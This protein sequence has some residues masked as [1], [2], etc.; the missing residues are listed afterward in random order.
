[1]PSHLTTC[2]R[3]FALYLLVGYLT[4]A[5][6]PTLDCQ[7]FQP[8]TI[9]FKG[10]SEY[11][12][13]ELAGVAKLKKGTVLTGA[14][15]GEHTKLLMDTGAFDKITYTFNGQDLVIELVPS[16]ALLPTQLDNFPFPAD[17]SLDDKLRTA[18]PL[19]HGK[20][21]L[22]GGLL[23]QVVGVLKEQL[24]AKGIQATLSAAPFV[25][26]KT[27]KSTAI[28]LSITTPAVEIGS[29]QLDGVS[30]EQAPKAQA[31]IA[32]LSGTPFSSEGSSSR[33]ETALGNFYKEQ[34]YLQCSIKATE[35]TSITSDAD[36]I[37]VPFAV[38]VNE[39]ALYH[40]ASVHLAPD[41]AVSQADFDKQA[42]VH[43]GDV[44]S[45]EKLRGEFLY[46]ARQYHNKGLMKAVVS[47]TASYE[48]TQHTVRY[49]ITAV[50]GPVYTMGSLQV[51]NVADDLRKAIVA[52]W[53]IQPGAP[54]NEG[55][56]RGMMATHDV[57]PALERVF[58]RS[59]AHYS[60]VLHDDS[61]T[62][63]VTLTLDR[64]N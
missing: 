38:S 28:S 26:M 6:V 54:F 47:Q 30:A 29:I 63:D 39:G 46:I 43:P 61:H 57:N 17:K 2:L 41:L 24:A 35:L 49:E 62:V 40:L 16:A 19:Y 51:Q 25:D 18:I 11:T 22:E 14:E 60:L 55:A 13:A 27:G 42:V 12:D 34:G 21:P 15:M 32:K 64:K 20:V 53:P 36:A 37:H 50:P 58:A 10:D 45:L 59:N 7:S 52:A 5:A 1:M 23:D 8:K 56:I 4:L 48:T 3:P 33:V 9:Q 44:A 31:A